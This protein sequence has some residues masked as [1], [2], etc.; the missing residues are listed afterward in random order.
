MTDIGSP[1]PQ[2]KL[3]HVVNWFAEITQEDHEEVK[4]EIGA[5]VGAQMGGS[6]PFNLGKI[7]AKFTAGV[8][9]GSSHATTTR[10]HLRN[11]PD[12]LINLTN[13]LLDAA[14]SILREN[15]K[16]GGLLLIFDNLDRYDPDIVD[17]V[18]FRQSNLVRKLHCHSVLTMPI[19]LEYEPRSGSA[20]DCYGFFAVLPMLSL[21]DR[22][23]KWQSTVAE[24]PYDEKALE[25]VRQALSKRLD[26]ALFENDADIDLL[27]RMSGG[28]IRDV[29]HCVALAFSHAGES[30]QFTSEA[31]R[32]SIREMRATYSTHDAGRL[33]GS[34]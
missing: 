13:S 12:R 9:A 18:L 25:A 28:C 3:R 7:F 10:V 8:K 20:Q 6:V 22:S 30:A 16:P 4:S 31:V 26:L 1:L 17:K 23:M 19:A 11:S 2:E 15:G 24:T 33:S 14:S 34:W 21:R 5:E 29:M 27:I 32:R